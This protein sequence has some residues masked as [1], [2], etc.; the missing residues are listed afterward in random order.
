MYAKIKISTVKKAKPFIM[1]A[2]FKQFIKA[3]LARSS[4]KIQQSSLSTGRKIILGLYKYLN[5]YI[6]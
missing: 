3:L 6:S 4:N 5:I 2:I 1:T